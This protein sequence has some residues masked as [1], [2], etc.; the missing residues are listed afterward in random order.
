MKKLLILVLILSLLIL[1]ASCNTGTAG[2]PQTTSGA[3]ET[4]T[5]E[6][7]INT[8]SG[9]DYD[10]MGEIIEIVGNEVTLKLMEFDSTETE[11]RVPGSGMGK[12]GGGVPSEKNYTGEEL[13]L[14]IP[15]GTLMVTRVQVL[16]SETTVASG[17]GTGTGSVEKEIG[18][19]ELA[20]GMF[21]KIRFFDGSQTIEKVLVQKPRT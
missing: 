10:I 16:N 8:A 2:E 15:V 13:I 18:F 17:S 7:G 1:S 3:A 9:N 19:N 6:A 12:N 4:T 5:P 21:L 14:I 20:K 11:T